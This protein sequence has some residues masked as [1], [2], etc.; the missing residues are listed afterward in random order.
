MNKHTR[1][2][3][4]TRENLCE[5]FIQL[6]A[7]K[8]LRHITIK[9]ITDRAGYNRGTF[10]IYYTD[11]YDILN[12]IKDHLAIQLQKSILNYLKEVK[13]PSFE[14]L[15]TVILKFYQK[16]QSRIIPLAKKDATMT[17]TLKKHLSPVI[18]LMGDSE[19]PAENIRLDYIL[20]YHLSA[21]I[22]F[23]NYWCSRNNDLS[24]QKLIELLLE[25]STAGALTLLQEKGLF[26]QL[27]AENP[28]DIDDLS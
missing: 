4:E 23:I 25:I 18:A 6:Y 26:H 11:V 24:S 17:A 5:A 27:A 14:T 15:I 3:H 9:D 19:D 28:F 21:V 1:K 20:E 13:S 7:E 12:Q 2:S 22:N 10:Y 16:N 8:D